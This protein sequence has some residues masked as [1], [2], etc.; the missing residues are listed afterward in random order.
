MYSSAKSLMSL[1]KSHCQATKRPKREFV[2]AKYLWVE[3]LMT[4]EET[5]FQ[6]AKMPNRSSVN[7]R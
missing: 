2:N 5:H 3:G 4:I 6:A 7:A 1:E